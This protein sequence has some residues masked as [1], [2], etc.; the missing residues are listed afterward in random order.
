MAGSKKYRIDMCHGSLFSQ[1]FRF[2]LPQ[3]G[4]NIMVLMFH[5]ADLIV[6]GQFAS[7]SV[8]TAA[9]AAVGATSAL[10]VLLLVFFSGFSAGVNSITARYVGARDH[11]KVSRTVHTSVA[12]G[13]WGGFFF[14][15]LGIFLARPVL[16]QMGTPPDVL[17]KA[18]IYLQISSIGLPFTVLYLIGAAIL[19]A[20]GDTSRPLVFIIIAGIVNV[21]LNIFF[22]T[23][24]KMDAAGVALATKI[25][26]LLSALLVLRTLQTSTGA[27][28]LSLRKIKFHWENLKE[29][30]WIGI[31]AGIQ[32]ALYSFSNLFI[33]SSVNSLGSA[34]MAGNAASQ[35]LEGMANVASGTYYQ[36]AMSFTGQNLGGQKYKRIIRSI[37]ICLLYATCFA[38][39]ANAFFLIF[40]K[41]LLGLYNPDPA[42]ISK[43]ME[44]LVIMMSTYFLC[45]IMDTISGA[46]R[47]LGHS[48]KPT[49]TTIMGACGLRIFWVFMIFPHFRTLS[50]LVISFPVS[51]FLTGGVNGIIL[52]FVCRQ[53]IEKAKA[54]KGF[55][56]RLGAKVQNKG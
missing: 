8:R 21:L 11:T 41:F 34:A 45:G 39:I 6:L 50:S 51:W 36:T 47:G 19:R 20:V 3:L 54:A 29:V 44:R 2:S 26:S 35:S 15:I 43:G 46:L 49:V 7:P 12:M 9:T 10:N 31:P 32:G 33:Q 1:I 52:Y 56:L 22:V 28:Q 5:A 4:N 16:I 38:F 17:D 25:S 14:A 55:T 23:V 53:M 42:V 24:F 13:I 48:V 40:G 18:V 30:L 37:F 27:I